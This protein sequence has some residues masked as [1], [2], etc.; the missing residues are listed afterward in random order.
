MCQLPSP[1][2]LPALTRSLAS[3]SLSRIGIFGGTF[4]P[5]HIAHL[6]TAIELREALALDS[7]NLLPCHKPSHRG[8]P[9]ASTAQR[10]RMLELS[11]EHVERL[12]ID[13]REAERNSPSY[14]VDTLA[15]YREEYPAAS[16]LLFMGMD[17]F[18]QFC[19]WYRWQHILEL[20]HLVVV[21]RPGSMLNGAEAQLLTDRQVDTIDK[22]QSSAGSILLQSV[23]QFDVSATRIRQLVSQNRDISYLV[24]DEV[25]RYINEQGLYSEPES[26]T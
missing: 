22:L 5:V 18:N 6:R 7:I 13:R 10:I 26:Q 12:Q 24:T 8:A 2:L 15:S 3:K 11:V 4:D 14:S 16:L 9:G 1:V 21:D 23:T 19:S 25:R 17:A 20:A